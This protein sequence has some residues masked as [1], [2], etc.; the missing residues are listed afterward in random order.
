MPHPQHKLTDKQ[1]YRGNSKSCEVACPPFS[2]RP[3]MPAWNET[4]ARSSISARHSQFHFSPLENFSAKDQFLVNGGPGLLVGQAEFGSSGGIPDSWFVHSAARSFP[5]QVVLNRSRSRR[6]DVPL[7]QALHRLAA[8][9]AWQ[10]TRRWA[11]VDLDPRPS[12]FD[13][14]NNGR[15]GSAPCSSSWRGPHPV[16]KPPRMP[17]NAM[18]SRA[19]TGSIP[20][21]ASARNLLKFQAQRPE[22]RNRSPSP[23]PHSPPDSAPSLLPAWA[24]IPQR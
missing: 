7:G 17:R 18:F 9:T 5:H 3:N 11:G 20:A 23:F 12:F 6:P 10:A 1:E 19:T 2:T 14:K 15:A 24:N 16:K 13:H 4:R 22:L 8:M 21:S